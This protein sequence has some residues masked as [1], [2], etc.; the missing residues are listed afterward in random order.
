LCALTQAAPPLLEVHP[1]EQNHVIAYRGRSS[2][3][4]KVYSG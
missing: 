4:R 2:I 1:A 3:G